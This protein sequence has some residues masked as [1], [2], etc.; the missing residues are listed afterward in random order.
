MLRLSTE[1]AL[2][3]QSQILVIAETR[4][5]SS[6]VCVMV[7]AHASAKP[8]IRPD[9]IWIAVVRKQLIRFAHVNRFFSIQSD[10]VQSSP[11]F[12]VLT[13]LAAD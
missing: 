3:V 1:A 5:Q 9:Y 13:E 10:L 6:A 8:Q 7:K 2:P 12:A 4:S 11:C